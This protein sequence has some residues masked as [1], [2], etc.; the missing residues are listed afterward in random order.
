MDDGDFL[1]YLPSQDQGDRD[2]IKKSIMNVRNWY[3]FNILN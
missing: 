3:Y 1:D 2:M